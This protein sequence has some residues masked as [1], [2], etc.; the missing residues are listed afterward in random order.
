MLRLLS[1]LR[2]LWE[3]ADVVVLVV[4]ARVVTASTSRSCVCYA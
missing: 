2:L 3:Q 1:R 4:D